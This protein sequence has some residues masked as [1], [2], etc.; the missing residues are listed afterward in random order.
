MVFTQDLND[1]WDVKAQHVEEEER[2][3]EFLGLLELE[4]DYVADNF[5]IV[6]VV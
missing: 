2:S 5:L 6:D 1:E 4:I 3:I